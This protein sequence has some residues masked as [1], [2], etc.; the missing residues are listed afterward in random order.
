MFY[1]VNTIGLGRSQNRRH[2][3]NAPRW[4]PFRRSGS[5]AGTAPPISPDRGGSGLHAKPLNAIIGQVFGPYR[6]GQTAG[7]NAK[8]NDKKVPYLQV[9]FAGPVGAPVHNQAHRPT[10]G[11][12][13]YHR[14]HW[15]TPPGEYGG[16][17]MPLVSIFPFFFFK[18]FHCRSA[19]KVA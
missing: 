10:E 9:V 16:R 1:C 18:F 2:R 8:K 7:S 5:C 15:L 14:S 12:Q 13:G 6:P 3:M 4:D 11:V 19:E 17:Y